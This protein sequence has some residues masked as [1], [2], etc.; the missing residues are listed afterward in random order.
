MA[1]IK[2]LI[3]KETGNETESQEE[4]EHK[5]FRLWYEVWILFVSKSMPWKCF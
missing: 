1:E 4:I 5:L 3:G 2:G